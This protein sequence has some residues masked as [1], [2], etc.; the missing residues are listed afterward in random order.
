VKLSVY[1]IN[2]NIHITLSK[3]PISMYSKTKPFCIANWKM[4]LTFDKTRE[5]CAMHE[6]ELR[7]LAL[8]N[9][10]IVLCPSPESLSITADFFKNSAVAIGAQNCSSFESGPYTGEVSALSLAQVGCT[11]GLVGHSERRTH[12]HET[13]HDSAL[14][15]KNFLNAAITPILCIGEPQRTDSLQEIVN[16]LTAQL[17]PVLQ[18]INNRAEAYSIGIAYEPVWAI[19]TGAVPSTERLTKIFTWLQE[20]CAKKIPSAR[21]FLIYGGS[22]NTDTIPQLKNIP[23][24][25]GFLIGGA[26]LDFQNFQKIVS[27]ISV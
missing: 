10:T 6:N 26:S 17:E 2:N 5:W 1:D 22:V 18:M 23:H 12:F 11:Y 9:S 14:K 7:T 24:L 27:L 4:N 15:V 3:G 8:H 19:G 21:H 13:V 20:T 16:T 25:E